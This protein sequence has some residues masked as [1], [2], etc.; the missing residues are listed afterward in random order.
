MLEGTKWWVFPF[1]A[2]CYLP[3][4]PPSV[5][6]LLQLQRGGRWGERRGSF[7]KRPGKGTSPLSL[8]WSENVCATRN[9]PEKHTFCLTCAVLC[10]LLSCYLQLN[11]KEA[12]NL[13]CR[14]SVG[15]TPLHCAAYRGQKQCI[16]KLLQSGADPCIKNNNGKS[17]HP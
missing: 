4:F 13:E 10:C 3:L 7:W 16:I 2:L 15:N 9:H 14:D 8:T 17:P 6:F 11:E 12:P 1:R 5:S